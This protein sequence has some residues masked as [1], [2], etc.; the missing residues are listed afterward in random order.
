MT[1]Y[2]GY[3]NRPGTMSSYESTEDGGLIVRGVIIMA[4]GEW[5]DMHGIKTIFSPEVLQACALQWADNAVWTR[6]AGGAPRS[7]TDK[8]GA[9]INPAYSPTENAVIGD[10][11]LHN[12]TDA[13]KACSALV[14]MA[15]EAGGIKDVSAETIVD[16][17]RDGTVLDVVFTGLALVED[18]ACE[19]CKL[20]AYSVQEDT[21]MADDE[22]K[23]KTTEDQT[24]GEDPKAEQPEN[25]P[26]DKDLL[27]MLVGFI[28]GLIPETKDLIAG[29]Q[30][31]EGEDRTRALGRLEGCMQAWGFPT[32]AEEYSKAMD[33]RL[34]SFEKSIDDK[35][36][37]I[38]NEIA[39]YG[40]PAGLKGKMGAEKETRAQRQTLVLYGSD[41]T[42]LY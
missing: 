35:L 25:E 39:Q 40:A 14:Q 15:R 18:G 16:L 21:T 41:R 2:K 7:V 34:A 31:S 26:K 42:A 32:V 3:Y 1:K 4:A 20:P 5:T 22:D 29:I 10:I 27:D 23:Q 11:Y 9:V 28:E 36:A 33:A 17:D 13:S 6:H 30:E 37:N 19:T 12:Q 38:Q 8:V 24:A